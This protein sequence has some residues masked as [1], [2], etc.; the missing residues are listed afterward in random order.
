MVMP[1]SGFLLYLNVSG[2]VPIFS[3]CTFYILYKSLWKNTINIHMHNENAHLFDDNLQIILE[4]C[5]HA[6]LEKVAEW[7]GLNQP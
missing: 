6:F 5:W 2:T 7:Q 4:H 3:I 1:G